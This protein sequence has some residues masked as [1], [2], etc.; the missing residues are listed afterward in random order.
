MDDERLTARLRARPPEATDIG[1]YRN[2]FLDPAVEEWL[3]PPPLQPFRETELNEML[4]NDERHWA[5]HG[6][7]PWV[8]EEREGGAVVGRAGLRWTEVDSRLAV[9][10]P[11]AVAPTHWGRGYATEA[12][13]AAIEWGE[14]LALPEVVALVMA[15]NRGSCRVAEKAGMDQDGTTLHAGLPHLVYRVRFAD[16]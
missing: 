10:L 9:E 3:R 15:R 12:A 7:G 13:V 16:R 8:L 6:F 4:G 1:A 11:W 14:S 5:D 2:L